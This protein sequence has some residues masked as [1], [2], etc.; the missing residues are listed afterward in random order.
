MEAAM[1]VET[2]EIWNAYEVF[3]RDEEALV[4]RAR[5]RV[6]PVQG[7]ARVLQPLRSEDTA[8]GRPHQGTFR[9]VVA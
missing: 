7:R 1:P 8:V 4:R 2:Q 6:S 3:C 5:E 9:H